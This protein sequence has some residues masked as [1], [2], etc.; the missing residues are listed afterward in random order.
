MRKTNVGL[1]IDH[2]KAVVVAVAGKSAEFSLTFSHAEKQLRRMGDSPLKGSY[3]AQKVPDDDV[4]ERIQKAQLNA[5]YDGLIAAIGQADA[6]LI[7]GPGEAKGE[8]KKRLQKN[9]LGKKIVGVE[10]ADK[11]TNAQIAA[12]VRKH[13]DPVK[14]PD[15]NAKRKRP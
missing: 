4:R 1:W 11:M 15:K 5:Y 9:K 13:F 14:E 10:S 12:R 3:E 2:Q 7:F 6:I 8:L